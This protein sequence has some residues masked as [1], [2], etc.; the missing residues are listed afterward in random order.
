VRRYIFGAFKREF[1][2]ELDRHNLRQLDV[3]NDSSGK[4]H[5]EHIPGMLKKAMIVVTDQRIL[6]SFWSCGIVL[7][8][9]AAMHTMRENAQAELVRNAPDAP[10]SVAMQSESKKARKPRAS[11]IPMPE[12]YASQLQVTN[13]L[14]I[15]GVYKKER[16]KPTKLVRGVLMTHAQIIENKKSQQEQ[17]I[18]AEAKTAQNKDLKLSNKRRAMYKAITDVSVAANIATREVDQVNVRQLVAAR[19]QRAFGLVEG[20]PAAT[21]QPWTLKGPQIDSL[22]KAV[23]FDLKKILSD[24]KLQWPDV[25]VHKAELRRLTKAATL[26]HTRL[27]QLR[28]AAES[29]CGGTPHVDLL[30]QIKRDLHEAALRVAGTKAYVIR[31]Y[32]CEEELGVIL[33]ASER[34]VRQCLFDVDLPWPDDWV[35]WAWNPKSK[36]NQAKR[37][38]GASSAPKPQTTRKRAKVDVVSEPEESEHDNSSE[39]VDMA[40]VQSDE[41]CS[42]DDRSIGDPSHASAEKRCTHEA[43]IPQLP[44]DREEICDDL[45]Y[46]DAQ[47]YDIDVDDPLLLVWP[48]GHWSVAV[49]QEQYT[50]GVDSETEDISVWHWG[51]HASRKAF[52]P[53]W[54]DRR[55]KEVFQ[56]TRPKSKERPYTDKVSLDQIVLVGKE[57]AA[58]HGGFITRTQHQSLRA[59]LDICEGKSCRDLSG[60]PC[61]G[62]LWDG[63]RP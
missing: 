3:C 62:C 25:S 32:Y 48:D 61:P 30:H 52:L 26:A 36:T 37:K 17:L 12:Q 38:A 23:E 54:R 33:D 63:R 10:H 1:Y 16:P 8:H 22:V 51:Y 46:F 59:Y 53:S 6:K 28:V 27:D 45:E 19:V 31:Q 34:K 56:K 55:G 14:A 9:S 11:V 47:G 60:V 2:D 18:A 20:L 58:L 21:I 35:A 29:A 50:H 41:G 5:Q 24:A 42:D 4:V 39:D 57:V 40:D 15:H 13:N 7:G 43:E 44:W 49:A